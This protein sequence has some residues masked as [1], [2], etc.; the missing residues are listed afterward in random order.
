[1]QELAGNILITVGV[2][3]MIFGVVGIYRFN[4]FY[5]RILTASTIDTV[6][7]ILLMIGVIVRSGFNY[8]SLKVFLIM[9][10]VTIINPVSTH[11]IVRSAYK[12]GFREK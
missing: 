2:V 8:F 5:A 6:G 10:I 1:M 7:F 11:S 12:S 9:I 3:F 4:K